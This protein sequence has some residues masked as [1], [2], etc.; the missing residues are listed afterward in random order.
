MGTGVWVSYPRPGSGAGEAQRGLCSLVESSAASRPCFW[1]E[2]SPKC[3]R[4]RQPCWGLR[5]QRDLEALP[6]GPHSLTQPEV[7]RKWPPS[8]PTGKGAGPPYFR[9]ITGNIPGTRARLASPRPPMD[10]L[11]AT[12]A[13]GRKPGV[14]LR[15]RGICGEAGPFAGAKGQGRSSHV[16]ALVSS[17]LESEKK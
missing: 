4:L 17:D 8:L 1:G 15:T 10:G 16:F 3:V 7:P 12:E 2:E 11:P 9:E 13:R 5:G 6:C 14:S